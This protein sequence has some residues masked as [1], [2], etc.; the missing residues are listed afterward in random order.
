VA[1]RL[2]KFDT[3]FLFVYGALRRGFPLHRHLKR[4][5]AK[6]APA[7]KVRAELLDSGKFPGAR[8]SDKAGKTVA[9][10]VYRLRNA[11]IALKVLDQVE[12]FSPRAPQRSLFQRAVTEIILPNGERQ[13]AWIY[14]RK[15]RNVANTR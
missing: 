14:W 5:G 7:A 1:E 6:F 11:A 15:D 9:G 3:D 12:G 13:M 10:E 2:P 4:L 8:K